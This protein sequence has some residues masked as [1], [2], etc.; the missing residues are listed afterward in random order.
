MSIPQVSLVLHHPD[1]LRL[2]ARAL[3]NT[4]LFNQTQATD[5]A[6]RA[7]V[8]AQAGHVTNA[9]AWEKRGVE[10]ARR[11]ELVQG[12]RQQLPATDTAPLPAPKI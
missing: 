8:L 5:A 9:Q 10:Y 6:R 12:L 1:S 2:L 4:L 7:A 3:D 11:A